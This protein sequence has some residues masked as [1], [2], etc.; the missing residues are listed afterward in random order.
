MAFTSQSTVSA[1]LPFNNAIILATVELMIQNCV[2]DHTVTGLKLCL[3]SENLGEENEWMLLSRVATIT[4][5]EPRGREQTQS[6]ILMCVS[7]I[8]LLLKVACKR[9]L[10]VVNKQWPTWAGIRNKSRQKCFLFK[11]QLENHVWKVQC[12]KVKIPLPKYCTEVKF[13]CTFTL[14]E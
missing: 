4:V 14:K 8:H 3:V 13:W 12:W 2:C 6:F 9:S 7:S 10:A 5:E 1:Q 11:S